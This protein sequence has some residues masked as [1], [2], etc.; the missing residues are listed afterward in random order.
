MPD[1]ELRARHGFYEAIPL[2]ESALDYARDKWK[3]AL[4]YKQ[5]AILL[6]QFFADAAYN[7]RAICLD[8]F[9]VQWG[10]EYFPAGEAGAEGLWEASA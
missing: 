1:F 4:C 2:N 6:P 9:S 10:G 7:A 3:A 8:G 5:Q